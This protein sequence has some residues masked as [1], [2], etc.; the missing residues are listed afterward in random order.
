MR[1]RQA[2][3]RRQDHAAVDAAILVCDMA[4]A[5]DNFLP[6]TAWWADTPEESIRHGLR[7]AA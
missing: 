6:A 5:D 2:Q 7:G 1:R 3:L 4:L